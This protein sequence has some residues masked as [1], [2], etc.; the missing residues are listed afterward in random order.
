MSVGIAT[1]LER[2]VFELIFPNIKQR[3]LGGKNKLAAVISILFVAR[4]IILIM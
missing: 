2:N 4:Y 1:I 3:D